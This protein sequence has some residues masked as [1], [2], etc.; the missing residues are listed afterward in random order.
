MQNAS[1]FCRLA[2]RSNTSV[3]FKAASAFP[4]QIS[5][6]GWCSRSSCSFM[7]RTR[8]SASALHSTTYFARLQ[9]IRHRSVFLSA[10]DPKPLR[11]HTANQ[12][13]CLRAALTAM[14]WLISLFQFSSTLEP[15]SFSLLGKLAV[16]S[17]PLPSR[18]P[19]PG[20]VRSH[21]GNAAIKY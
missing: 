12:R 4:R 10:S 8:C 19:C 3:M 9:L 6:R 2:R 17:L 11:L 15:D 1:L 14:E 21:E 13:S 18:G 16:P 7:T 5:A 20:A